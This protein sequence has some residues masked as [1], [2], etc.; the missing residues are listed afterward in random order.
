M[1]NPHINQLEKATLKN[2]TGRPI[3]VN[4]QTYQPDPRRC[5][6]SQ[7]DTVTDGI[8]VRRNHMNVP[9]SENVVYILPPTAAAW[10]A[11]NGQTNVVSYDP[12]RNGGGRWAGFVIHA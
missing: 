1:T 3:T 7:D 2:W 6:V 8:T 12:A 11:A 4:G 10:L 9:D 5:G